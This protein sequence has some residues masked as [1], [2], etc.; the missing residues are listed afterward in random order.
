MISAILLYLSL[1]GYKEPSS[2]LEEYI[3]DVTEQRFLKETKNPSLK[4][5]KSLCSVKKLQSRYGTLYSSTPVLYDFATNTYRVG[6]YK[7]YMSCDICNQSTTIVYDIEFEREL[8]IHLS[9][10]KM[11]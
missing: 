5:K 6:A 3:C 9:N 8:S 10:V 2:F 4:V 1:N 7:V 11:F